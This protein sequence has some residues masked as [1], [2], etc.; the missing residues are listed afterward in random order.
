MK[1]SEVPSTSSVYCM[2]FTGTEI[3]AWIGSYLL[4]LFRISA[5]VS[6]APVFGSRFIPAR[7]KIAISIVLTIIVVS[8]VPRPAEFDPVSLQAVLIV[9]QQ[10]LIGFAMGFAMLLVFSVF[11]TGGQMIALSMGLGFATMVDP[12]NGTQVP[13][14][15]QFYQI[16]VTL[17]FLAFNGHL[18]LIEVMIDSFILIPISAEGL[19]V[20]SYWEIVSWGSHLF[21]GAV[22]L[23]LPIIS[24]LLVVNLALGVIMRASPQF[25]I[26]SIGFPITLT[27]GFVIILI[28]LPTFIPQVSQH[29]TAGFQLIGRILAGG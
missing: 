11:V 10:M 21:Q 1:L 29:V 8:I 19:T 14:V 26:L 16:L 15:S 25:N 24:A 6:I 27:L 22:V 17:A 3:T 18:I 2:T 23:A 7:I 4:P 20:N 9:I 12:Q 13:V 28:S 5:M